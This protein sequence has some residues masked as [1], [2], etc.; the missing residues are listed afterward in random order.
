MRVLAAIRICPL[1]AMKMDRSSSPSVSEFPV[2]P[3]VRLLPNA[4]SGRLSVLG[5]EGAYRAQISQ[6]CSHAPTAGDAPD[7]PGGAVHQLSA[8]I[9]W[10]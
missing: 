2:P 5:L 1:A 8:V 10:A 7:L 9:L 3:A 6:F 4:D